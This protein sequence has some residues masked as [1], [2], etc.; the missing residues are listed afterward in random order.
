V[1]AERIWDLRGILLGRTVARCR[2]PC[3][4][5]KLPARLFDALTGE[6]ERSVSPALTGELRHLIS[7]RK[8]AVLTADELRVE[9]ASL[10]GWIGGLV[11]EM[12]SQIEVAS[13]KVTRSRLRTH[14]V[15]VPFPSRSRISNTIFTARAALRDTS[16]VP[17]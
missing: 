13:E 1:A 10:L 4:F 12:L 17:P 16:A 9:Y 3:A 8:A 14:P 6:L 15:T 5:R 11:I 2:I 7:Q